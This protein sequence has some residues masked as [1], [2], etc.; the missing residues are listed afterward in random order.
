VLGAEY[1]KYAP[2]LALP[3]EPKE[4]G[5]SAIGIRMPVF[6]KLFKPKKRKRVDK[7]ARRSY[8]KRFIDKLGL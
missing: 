7:K 1:A 3:K 2:K 5:I 4:I 8:Q 6:G